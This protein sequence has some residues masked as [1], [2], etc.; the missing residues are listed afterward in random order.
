MPMK[1]QNLDKLPLKWVECTVVDYYA[2]LFD[3]I[4]P[5]MKIETAYN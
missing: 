3:I 1:A 2:I 4:I 5:N